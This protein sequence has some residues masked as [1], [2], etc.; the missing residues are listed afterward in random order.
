M[1][2]SGRSSGDERHVCAS[3]DQISASS[4][5]ELRSYWIDA[6]RARV[7]AP[8][9]L[10]NVIHTLYETVGYPLKGSPSSSV[11]MFVP[12]KGAVPHAIFLTWVARVPNSS[13]CTDWYAHS[14]S[15]GIRHPVSG[16][17]KGSLANL[18]TFPRS[19]EY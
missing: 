14:K 17:P 19:S 9:E 8:P 4:I 13:Y 11:D 1:V 6:A 5:A 18:L 2:A 12:R 7:L 10:S 3:C 15:H 16:H